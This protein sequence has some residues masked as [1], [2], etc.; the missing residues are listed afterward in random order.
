MA[1]TRDYYKS[2]EFLLNYSWKGKTKEQII[3]DM[4]L[5]T[6]EQRY[7]DEAMKYNE[8]KED[9]SGMALDRYILQKLDEEDEEDDFDQNNTIF[10]HR[11]DD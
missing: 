6:D 4:R 7:L 5:D 3:S 2:A 8:N 9:Y 11:D 1:E 10:I